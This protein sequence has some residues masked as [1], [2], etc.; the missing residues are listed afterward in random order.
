MF[1]SQV[2]PEIVV[3]FI[4]KNIFHFIFHFLKKDCLLLR[5]ARYWEVV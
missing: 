3:N 1:C 5:G 2:L 4:Q